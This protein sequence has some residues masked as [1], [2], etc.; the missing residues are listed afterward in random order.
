MRVLWFTD[1]PGNA[2]DLLDGA[3][4]GSS[5]IPALDRQI[6]KH[7]ELHIA[8]DYNKSGLS[9]KYG[10]T[11]YH[12][13]ANRWWKLF[14]LLQ[15]IYPVDLSKKCLQNYLELI[16]EI[17]PDIIHLHGTE[18]KYGVIL[19]NTNVPVV[20]SI[21]GLLIEIQRK[22]L[23][24]YSIHDIRSCSFSFKKSLKTQILNQSF[25]RSW[26]RMKM[27]SDIECQV[28]K[29]SHYLIGRTGWDKRI[30]SVIAPN[31]K[32]YHCDEMLRPCFY[33]KRWQ[34][35]QHETFI[36]HSTLSNSPY[37]GFLVV[38]EALV[39]LQRL[40]V[41][42]Q[43]QVAGLGD[44]ESIVAITKRKLKNNYPKT[45]LNLVGK[46]GASTLVSLMCKADVF[47]LPS[48]IENS[49]NSLCEA[50]LLGMP[51]IASF[52]GGTSS[53][54]IDGIEGILIPN[55]DPYAISGAILE[56]M[57]KPEL[58]SQLSDNARKTALKRHNPETVVNQVLECY[59]SILRE[60]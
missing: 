52:S 18:N 5:W 22:Y 55:G 51:C 13:I 57:R 35:H 45:G 14:A 60:G 7:I 50:M 44:E 21:Q 12:P 36:I 17:N 46:V 8:F 3:F 31:S 58:A 33:E 10:E 28:L 56:I 23:G 53:L 15:Q 1:S 32:Y 27:L 19:S 2:I 26:R 47:V 42:I 29:R 49:S 41:N 30:L 37:K 25:L 4:V 48:F 9:F 20:I 24:D 40:G 54:L 43:W 16:N 34:T 38:C 11:T 59:Q 39:S 6:Q